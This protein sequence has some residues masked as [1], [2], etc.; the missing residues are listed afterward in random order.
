MADAPPGSDHC[1]IVRRSSII[2]VAL[3]DCVSFLEGLFPARQAISAVLLVQVAVAVPTEARVAHVR[4]NRSGGA[5]EPF[6]GG[7]AGVAASVPG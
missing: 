1:V 5:V 6:D 2:E 7:R 3:A 4:G